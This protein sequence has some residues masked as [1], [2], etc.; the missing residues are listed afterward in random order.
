MNSFKNSV[1][2]LCLASLCSGVILHLFS[3][4]AA[5]R[6]IKA[7]AGLY[8]LVAVLGANSTMGATLATALEDA[9]A[10]VQSTANESESTLALETDASVESI[11]LAQT[12]AQ[13]EAYFLQKFVAEGYPILYTDIT[14][15]SEDGVAHAQHICIESETALSIE[16][17]QEISLAIASELAADEVQFTVQGG[18]A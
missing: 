17:Q 8:I 4:A 11:L 7:V 9:N 1:L 10:L 15:V 2:V 18:D 5:K 13:L 14:L 3:D 6:C 12:E 16:A